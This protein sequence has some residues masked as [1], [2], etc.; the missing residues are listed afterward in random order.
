MNI[1]GDGP[2]V[3]VVQ[4][5]IQPDHRSWLAMA[6]TAKQELEDPLSSFESAVW[7]NFGVNNDDGQKKQRKC[8]K[9]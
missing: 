3:V 5:A 8:T 2:N 4:S 6:T 7:E 9:L 1:F